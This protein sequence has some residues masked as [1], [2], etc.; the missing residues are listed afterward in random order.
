MMERGPSYCEIVNMGRP[1]WRLD[2]RGERVGRPVAHGELLYAGACMLAAAS[3]VPYY[4][5]GLRAF[6]FAD[7][8]PGMMQLRVATQIGVPTMLL[9]LG[10]IWSGDFAH[11]GLLDFH[12]ERVA[13]KFERPM[14]LQIGG[15]AEGWRDEVCFGMAASPVEIVDF[16][17][18]AAA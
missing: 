9:N 12:A 8:A 14:P 4:G 3:T 13:L 1:A 16:G 17:A 2:H 11:E 5:L 10:K 6:P 7:R 15:D 18:A